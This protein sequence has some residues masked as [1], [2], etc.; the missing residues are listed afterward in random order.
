MRR[1]QPW[2][3][4]R[5][6]KLLCWRNK[7]ASHYFYALQAYRTQQSLC[8][9]YSKGQSKWKQA[10]LWDKHKH[11]HFSVNTTALYYTSLSIFLSV[12]YLFHLWFES[13]QYP[14]KNINYTLEN[15]GSLLISRV[16]RRNFIISGTLWIHIELFNC[17]SGPVYTCTFCFKRRFRMRF[18]SFVLK[19]R[20]WSFDTETKPWSFQTKTVSAAF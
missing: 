3:W 8:V 1:K 20:F 6:E 2:N 19:R 10:G 15:R 9:V 11:N 17:S 18:W 16:P 5:E 14:W 13:K 12:Q 4:E 7:R